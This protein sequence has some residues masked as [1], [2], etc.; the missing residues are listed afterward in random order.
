MAKECILV[1]GCAGFIGSHTVARLLADGYAVRGVDDFSTGSEENIAPYLPHMEVVR[2]SLAD[3]SAAARAVQG[4]DLVIHLASI[5]SVPR[6]VDNPLESELAS[7]RAT[8]T[9]FDAARRVNVRRIVQAASSSAYGCQPGLPKVETHLPA[10]MSP[11]A[12]AKLAQEMYGHAFWYSYG[13]DSIALRYFNVFGPRQNPNGDYAAVIPKFITR[14]LAGQRPIIYGDGT[15]T[16][17][18]TYIDNVVAA[19]VGA[20]THPGTMGGAVANI[21]NGSPVSLNDLVA[22]LNRVLGTSLEPEYQPPRPGDIPHSWAQTDRAR[23]LFGY[24]GTVGLEEGVLRTARSFGF[25][26]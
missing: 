3:P 26:G 12:V 4:A 15:Q 9:L 25:K 13:F 14:M 24:V 22:I 19:N 18:F 10:P 16:R 8:V 17:D 1:T 5:P 21:G 23:Q 20:A 7:I 2:G 11:Y 6:S